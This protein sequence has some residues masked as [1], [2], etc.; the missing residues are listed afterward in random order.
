MDYQLPGPKLHPDLDLD[1]I[2]YCVMAEL[3]YARAKF[4]DNKTNFTALVEEV[5]ELAEAL[6][7]KDTKAVFAEAVQVVV[8][9]IRVLQEPDETHGVTLSYSDYQAFDVNKAL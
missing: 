3:I 5:G 8:M 1:R 4:P 7:K 2:M 9:A 6:L